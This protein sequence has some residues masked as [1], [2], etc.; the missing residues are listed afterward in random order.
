MTASPPPS[1]TDPRYLT[2]YVVHASQ[3]L[4]GPKALKMIDTGPPYG[5]EVVANE[6]FDLVLRT[7]EKVAAE[8]C[9]LSLRQQGHYAIVNDKNNFLDWLF[10]HNLTPQTYD[11][12]LDILREQGAGKV[13]NVSL[14][15]QLDV[16]AGWAASNL[17]YAFFANKYGVRPTDVSVIVKSAREVLTTSQAF[18]WPHSNLGGERAPRGVVYVRGGISSPLWSWG[19]PFISKAECSCE[20]EPPTS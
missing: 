5:A 6:T 4:Y 10:L 16:F 12:A 19:F 7:Y 13:K 20:V 2:E 1:Q 18:W 9:Q 11:L 15:K 3:R 14:E 17:S 8:S